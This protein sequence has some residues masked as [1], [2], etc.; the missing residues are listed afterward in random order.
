MLDS[1]LSQLQGET[2]GGALVG[3]LGIDA[4]FALTFFDNVLHDGQA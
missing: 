3:A 2:K 4:D 1:L